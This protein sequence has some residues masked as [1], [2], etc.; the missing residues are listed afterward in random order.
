MKASG[1]SVAYLNYP[2]FQTTSKTYS[3]QIWRSRPQVQW[4]AKARMATGANFYIV[5][6]D[7]A[8]MPHP[9]KS[10]DLYDHSHGRR[11]STNNIIYLSQPEKFNW[12]VKE[13]YIIFWFAS[14]LELCLGF[15]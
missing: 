13:N 10:G 12:L 7:P 4:H 15:L 11:V 3:I 1:F 14:L 9:D 5:G 8:G 2:K 6:R